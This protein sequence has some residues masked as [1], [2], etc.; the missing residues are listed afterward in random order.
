MTLGCRACG[1]LDE[2]KR[3]AEMIEGD[4][5]LHRWGAMQ[6]LS[7]VVVESSSVKPRK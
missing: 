7:S 5:F 6:I 3:V 4:N 2:H 1:V